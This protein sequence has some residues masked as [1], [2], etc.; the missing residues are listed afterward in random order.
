MSAPR[1]DPADLRAGIAFAVLIAD[2]GNVEKREAAITALVET[3]EA[4]REATFRA[5]EATYGPGAAALRVPVA[6][7]LRAR[8]RRA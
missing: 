1:L 5:L 2:P 8:E 4:D 7:M 3:T 6:A